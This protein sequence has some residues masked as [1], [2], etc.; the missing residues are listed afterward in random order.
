MHGVSLHLPVV[1]TLPVHVL[2]TMCVQASN[3]LKE[4][5]QRHSSKKYA[6]RLADFHL[7]L[8][9]AVSLHWQDSDLS[10]VVDAVKQGDPIMEGYTMM[11][12]SMAGL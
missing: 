8:W 6:D 3:D 2:T 10:L 7:L 4:H 9:L 1:D 11:I 12:D 5:L